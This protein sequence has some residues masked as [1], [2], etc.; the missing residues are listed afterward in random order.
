ME[1]CRKALRRTFSSTSAVSEAE[2][3][4]NSWLGLGLGLGLRVG[5]GVGVKG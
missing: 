1:A 5:V 4:S 3:P 2:R